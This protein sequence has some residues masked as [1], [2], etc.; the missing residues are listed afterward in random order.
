MVPCMA[1]NLKPLPAWLECDERKSERWPMNF[2]T[3][4]TRFGAVDPVAAQLVDLSTHGCLLST[5]GR[6][7]LGGFVTLALPRSLTVEGW[8][9][10]SKDGHAGLDFA[11]PLPLAVVKQMILEHGHAAG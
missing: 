2:A 1:T 10:W 11:H 3:T 4:F 7:Q 9:A 6:T 5:P 8:I